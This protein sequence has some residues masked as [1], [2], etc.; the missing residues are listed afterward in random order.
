MA[1]RLLRIP[2]LTLFSGPNCSLCDVA[3]A[4]L[5][6]VRQQREFQL[7]TINIQDEGQER[8]KRK[9]VYWIPALHIEGKEI[10]KGRWDAQTQTSVTE[11]T[12]TEPLYFVDTSCTVNPWYES[13]IYGVYQRDTDALLGEEEPDEGENK[14]DSSN[15][16]LCF[17]CG[18]PEHSVSA[19]PIRRN[20][21]LI[22][23]SRQYFDFFKELRGSVDH[24]RAYLAEGWRQQRLE[25]LEIFEPGCVRNPILREAIGS[26]EGDQW[27]KNIANWG[28]PPGWIS[29]QDPKEK[30]RARLW[31]EFL[32][33]GY[34]CT[35]DSFYI[36]QDFD[37]VE[38]VFEN[39]LHR[40]GY[41]ADSEKEKSFDLNSAPTRW[42]KYPLSYFSSDL[43]FAYT[44]PEPPPAESNAVLDGS[45]DYYFHQLYAQP[46]PPPGSPPPIPPPPPTSP[47]PPLPPPPFQPCPPSPPSS[48]PHPTHLD[49]LSKSGTTWSLPAIP[50]A[51]TPPQHISQSVTTALSQEDELDMD[52]SDTE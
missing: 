46:P 3:K 12:P 45:E 15:I 49:S 1:S 24:P 52:I 23:L 16:R 31:D 35:N 40:P 50:A 28:Y 48:L 11:P 32:D 14:A 21:E 47:P 42:A 27:L 43:L 44:R 38:D 2:R 5:A 9:Y 6:R 29:I 17:N 25:W 34:N 20:H 41:D 22:S 7:E 39:I 10:A 26:E 37:D 36:F 13:Y 30:V 4:E 51:Q 18:S 8:W 33:D 19:C